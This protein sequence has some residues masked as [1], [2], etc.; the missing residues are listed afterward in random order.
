METKNAITAL[1]ALAQET[2]LSIFRALVRAGAEGL[3]AGA[4]ADAVGTAASTL[5]FHL[6]ELTNAGLVKGR[7]DGRFIFYTADYAAMS[8]L[9]AYLTENCCQGMPARNI[10]RIG[11]AVASCCTPSGPRKHGRAA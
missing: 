11:Q 3:P 4:I 2:R 9:V 8:E 5:S 7:Q 10:A 6:K 1:A